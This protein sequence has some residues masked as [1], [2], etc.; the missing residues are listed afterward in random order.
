MRGC[1]LVDAVTVAVDAEESVE[2]IDFEASRA[3]CFTW[4]GTGNV[5]QFPRAYLLRNVSDVQN[6]EV[7]FVFVVVPS[8]I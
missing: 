1:Q 7:P 3:V 4:N 8:N 5:K 2:V 6:F